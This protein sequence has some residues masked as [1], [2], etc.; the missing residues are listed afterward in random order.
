MAVKRAGSFV[1]S[2]YKEQRFLFLLIS[3]LILLLL[4]PI[5]KSFFHL[6]ILI[7]I[8]FSVIFISGIYAVSQKKQHVYISS[9]LAVPMLLTLWVT[10][11]IEV[12]GLTLS[13]AFCGIAFFIYMIITI[14]IYIF[15]Q[16]RV[17]REVIYAAV[18]VYLLMGVLWAFV[19]GA[20]EH[21][22]PHSF[23]GI[24]DA[25]DDKRFV[26]LYYSFVTLTTLGYGDISPATPMASSLAILE[27][28][29]GQLYLVVQIAWL[30]GLRVSQSQK[31]I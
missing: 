8:F 3:I 13:G 31:G 29:I 17:N 7:D 24:T 30:V 28:I 26:F 11:F 15:N 22:Q 5:L 10:Y 23:S 21:I 18:V 12:P 14:L 2:F 9:F 1:F 20:V 6:K 25:I 19:Y 4:S 16:D 27:A